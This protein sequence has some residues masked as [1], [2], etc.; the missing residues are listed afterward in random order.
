MQ[1]AC[2][3]SRLMFTCR[4]PMIEALFDSR[5]SPHLE[6]GSVHIST[7]GNLWSRTE[8]V[9]FSNRLFSPSEI[10]YQLTGY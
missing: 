4:F 6:N 3:S 8:R 10:D 9:I 1:S 5:R 2:H 7:V